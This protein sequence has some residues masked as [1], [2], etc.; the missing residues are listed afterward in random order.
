[1]SKLPQWTLQL[2][3]GLNFQEECDKL[4]LDALRRY[5][6]VAKREERII[7]ANLSTLPDVPH[8]TDLN[9]IARMDCDCSWCCLGRFNSVWDLRTEVIKRNLIHRKRELAI[10]NGWISVRDTPWSLDILTKMSHLRPVKHEWP[11]FDSPSP[12]PVKRRRLR[13]THTTSATI[14]GKSLGTAELEA[15]I[16]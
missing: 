10:A 9:V 5:Y 8:I 15:L 16:I 4:S 11:E 3:S 7:W 14:P 6:I 1:M 13:R 2:P 12:S